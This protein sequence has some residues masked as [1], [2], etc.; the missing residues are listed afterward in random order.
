MHDLPFAVLADPT[1][2]R[3]VELLHAGERSV[4]ELVG[5]VGIAQPGVSRHLRILGE[6]GLVKARPQG[7]RRLYSLRPEPLRELELWAHR[8]AH[9]ERERLERLADFVDGT[10]KSKS[11]PIRK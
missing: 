6:A 1:R 2:R 3:L 8:H 9:V 5:K 4:G 10:S 7:Q 11:K